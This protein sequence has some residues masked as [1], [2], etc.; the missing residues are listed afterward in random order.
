MIKKNLSK[1]NGENVVVNSPK[2]QLI[3]G[4]GPN[5]NPTADP[6]Q[7]KQ[8]LSKFNLHSANPR[9]IRSAC[10]R[11]QP[12]GLR[13][14]SKPNPDLLRL[15]DVRKDL[16]KPSKCPGPRTAL[17]LVSMPCYHSIEGMSLQ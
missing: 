5:F 9:K 6:E 1:Q 3:L 13:T 4:L 11:V 12:L 17:D 2:S 8:N 14:F 7:L 16:V 10:S 15:L